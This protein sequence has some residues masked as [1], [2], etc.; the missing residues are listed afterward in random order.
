M[1]G[2]KLLMRY[3]SAPRTGMYPDPSPGS[4]RQIMYV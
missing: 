1:G 2:R 4:M 3:L